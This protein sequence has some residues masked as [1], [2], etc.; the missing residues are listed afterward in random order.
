MIP[1]CWLCIMPRSHLMHSLCR[2]LG[3]TRGDQQ[4]LHCFNYRIRQPLSALSRRMCC[5]TV[6]S[7]VSQNMRTLDPSYITT[8]LLPSLARNRHCGES[9]LSWQLTKQLVQYAIERVRLGN[10]D[11][12]ASVFLNLLQVSNE[13]RFSRLD[14]FGL[15]DEFPAEEEDR[16]QSDL[17]FVSQMHRVHANDVLP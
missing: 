15:L 2:R 4:C 6:Q 16:K 14:E 10:L 7:N 12:V 11:V 13:I 9:Y 3:T 1:R 5:S 8:A 17:R